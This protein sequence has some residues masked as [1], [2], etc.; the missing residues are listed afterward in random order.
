M[1]FPARPVRALPIPLQRR[2]PRLPSRRAPRT[3]SRPPFH[4]RRSDLLPLIHFAL[5][6]YSKHVHDSLV[7][8]GYDLFAKTDVRFLEAV[9]KLLRQE[10][11][12]RPQVNY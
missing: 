12:Y 11:A 1:S 8:K 9:Y 2:G 7:A 5:L 6:G 4:H 10:F 3:H